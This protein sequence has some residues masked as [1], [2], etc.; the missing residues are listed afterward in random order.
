MFNVW[1]AIGFVPAQWRAASITPIA[2]VDHPADW[3][4]YR[5][6]SL[7]SNLCKVFEKVLVKYIVGH[8]SAIWVDNNQHGFLPG[9]STLD[10]A[11]T[12]IFDL[13]SAYDRGIPWLAIFF[14][15]AK[16]FDLV[17]HDILL[18]KL[19]DVLPLWLV[20]WVACYLSN[21]TQRV[22]IGETTSHWKKVE[23]GVIQGSVLGPV[24]FILLIA[25]INKYM[26]E[27]VRFEKYTDDIITYIVGKLLKT[28]LPKQV[29]EAVEK[30]CTDNRM[31]L[32]VTKCKVMHSKPSTTFQP[33]EI[34]LG[35]VILES[36]DEYKYLGFHVNPS[37]DGK[38]QW[39]RV[40]PLIS[41][42]IALSKQLRSC[43][44]REP[45]LA[46]VFKSLVLSHM[47]YSS[48][49]LVACPTGIIEDM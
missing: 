45:I 34:K 17:P 47:H 11:L 40:Q 30:W 35:H 33:P 27:G 6:I 22:R 26:P 19:A 13:E 48:T 46:A 2:K 9:R 10:A 7:T 5:P 18:K 16:A 23:A 21:R 24:L 41:K 1:L 4:D 49:L 29:V 15:F 20:R 36:V 31:R 3:S 28:D 38:L 12:V 25:D 43:G 42:N 44:L 8:T 14:D 37:F 32:N 39:N